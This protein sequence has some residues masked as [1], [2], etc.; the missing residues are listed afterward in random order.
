MSLN[1]NQNQTLIS[2]IDSICNDK[3]YNETILLGDFNLPDA[4]WI[5][6][7]VKCNADTDNKILINQ[8]KFMELFNIK[9]LSWHFSNE[10]TRRRL[11]KGVLQESLLD[12]VLTTNDAL[13][14]SIKILPKLGKSDHVCIKVDLGVSLGRSTDTIIHKQIWSKVKSSDLSR[15]S[16]ENIDWVYSKDDLTVEKMWCEL[17]KKLQSFDAVVPTAAFHSSGRP[18]KLPWGTS[19]LNRLRI[20]KDKAWNTFDS[21][22]TITN[23]NNAMYRENIY[24]NEHTRLKINYERKITSDLKNNCKS[25]YSYLRNSREIKTCIR[26]LD[27][28]DGSRTNNSTESAEVLANA[29]SSVF[30]REPQG[31]L[32][33]FQPSDASCYVDIGDVVITPEAVSLKLS[34]LNIFKSYG[35]DKVHPKLLRSLSEDYGFIEAVTKLFINCAKSGTIPKVWKTASVTALFKNGSKYDPLNYRMVSLT[36]ILCKV[37]E[38]FIREHILN[39]IEGRISTHQ[40][41]FV[42]KKSCLTINNCKQTF[43]KI[44]KN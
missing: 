13:L 6:G 31:P 19:R 18:V 22:P 34:K 29:F 15:F 16:H 2:C 39:F 37:Y 17:H 40:H 28:G 3:I 11:V 4:C 24:D 36:C 42:K 27:K 43:S 44:I 35:P 8:C 23:F 10:T 32:P 1:T 7:S 5:T 20:S 26:N 38:Q 12:Q 33:E 41:G 25:L 9:G 14:N 21:A 30:V